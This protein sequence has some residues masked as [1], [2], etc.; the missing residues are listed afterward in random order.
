[1]AQDK[2]IEVEL[3]GEINLERNGL[4]SVGYGHCISFVH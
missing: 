3:D 2:R 1:M 4:S